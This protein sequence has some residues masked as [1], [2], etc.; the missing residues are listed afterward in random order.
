[1]GTAA[2]WVYYPDKELSYHRILVRHNFLKDSKGYWTETNSERFT[3][4][5]ND[6]Y[7]NEYAYPL[8]TIT[9][10]EVMK[11]LLAWSKSKNVIGLGRW[12]E[13][14]HYNSDVTVSLA[15]KLAEE[16]IQC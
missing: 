1:M 11:T 4:Q 15:M 5:G 6:Y 12:G 8:N 2:H 9:K 3:P 16:M 7:K 10:P 13:W 14:E